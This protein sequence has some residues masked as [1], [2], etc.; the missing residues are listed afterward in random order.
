[1]KLKPGCPMTADKLHGLYAQATERQTVILLHNRGAGSRFLCPPLDLAYQLPADKELSAIERSLNHPPPLLSPPGHESDVRRERSRSPYCVVDGVSDPLAFLTSANNLD[2]SY[3]SSNVITF[4][5]TTGD[6]VTPLS[7][8]ILSPL[9]SCPPS[10]TYERATVATGLL[11]AREEIARLGRWSSSNLKTCGWP[12]STMTAASYDEYMKASD[13]PYPSTNTA[14]RRA[15]GKGAGAICDVYEVQILVVFA[16]RYLN[17][18]P[19]SDNLLDRSHSPL[20]LL[21]K[22][23]TGQGAVNR[24]LLASSFLAS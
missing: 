12:W 23:R 19:Y 13:W 4:P 14:V 17:Q 20:G 15:R 22:P 11:V 6:F 24:Q 21:I 10:P 5:K 9:P 18:K 8:H 3:P 2:R 7:K 1:M 16:L